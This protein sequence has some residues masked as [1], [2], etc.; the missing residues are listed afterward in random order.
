MENEKNKNNEQYTIAEIGMV[1]LFFTILGAGFIGWTYS[2]PIIGAKMG[3]AFGIMY[4]I[5]ILFCGRK[6]KE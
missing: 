2:K 6:S 4:G 3:L 5:K 1:I